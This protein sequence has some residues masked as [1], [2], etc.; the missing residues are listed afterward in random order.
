MR[1]GLARVGGCGGIHTHIQNGGAPFSSPLVWC[2]ASSCAKYTPQISVAFP[3][4][5]TFFTS[6]ARCGTCHYRVIILSASSLV[7]YVLCTSRVSSLPQYVHVPATSG[8]SLFLVAR[9]S[10]LIQAMTT[11]EISAHVKQLDK[12][13]IL[14][15]TDIQV[16]LH[17]GPFQL[18]SSAVTT[19][20][21]DGFP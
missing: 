12:G 5:L 16:S 4:F 6:R 19:F 20:T 11:E 17:T 8:Q 3:K 7:R 21:L 15:R 13:I 10:S 14:D 2:A 18:E 1:C 9:P